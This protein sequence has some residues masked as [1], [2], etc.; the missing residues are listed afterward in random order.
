MGC[1]QV[2]TKFGKFLHDN[3]TQ[4]SIGW[5]FQMPGEKDEM[6]TT[7][8]LFGFFH[9]VDWHFL[10]NQESG[11][12]IDKGSIRKDGY[13]IKELYIIYKSATIEQIC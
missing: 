2:S 1:K 10:Y 6:F 8:V 11:L 13:S 12:Y 5:A 7:E 9:W 4:C 3:Y